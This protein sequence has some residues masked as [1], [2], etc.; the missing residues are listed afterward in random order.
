MPN[1]PARCS[2]PATTAAAPS[3][4]GGPQ[5]RHQPPGRRSHYLAALHTLQAG[6][7]LDEAVATA[8]RE[9]GE[10]A[11]DTETLYAVVVLAC[12]CGRPDVA[13]RPPAA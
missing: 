5:A 1:P 12:A 8:E 13:D 6:N 11:D 10:L 7:L 3:L 9:L 4:P 2:K